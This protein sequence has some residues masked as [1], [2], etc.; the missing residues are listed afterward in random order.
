MSKDEPADWERILAARSRVRALFEKRPAK[1]KGD[2][3]TVSRLV[4]G[5][6]CEASEG[7]WRLTI[8]QPEA[9][10]GEG[11]APS[12]GFVGRAALG[13]CLVQGYA[14]ALAG[15]GVAVE[16]LE[17]EVFGSSDTR[18]FLGVPGVPPGYADVTCRVSLKAD[19]NP[20]EIDALLDKAERESPWLN[21]L[22]GSVPMT[23]EV[24]LL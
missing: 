8:D 18:G 21:N 6:V 14:L 11:S 23:R 22:T 7:P 4:R 1:A 5:M 24:T 15:A 16:S 12:P 2:G 9:M 3:R 19:A 17:V 10:G 13:A 20:G